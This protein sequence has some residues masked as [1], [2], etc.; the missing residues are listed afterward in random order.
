MFFAVPFVNINFKDNISQGSLS[1]Q[2]KINVHPL[3]FGNSNDFDG[4][5]F[6]GGYDG[7]S[8]GGD[9]GSGGSDY[10]GSGNEN[11][12]FLIAIMIFVVIPVCTFFIKAFCGAYKDY[13]K[14]K[15]NKVLQQSAGRNVVLLNRNEKI[16]EV[17]RQNDPTFITADFLQFSK[18]V[19][20]DIQY[21][22]SSRNLEPVRKYLHENLYN[23]TQ[24]Q[25][26]EKIAK[27]IVDV[28]KDVYVDTVCLTAYRRDREFEYVTVYL[29]AILTDYEIDER[30]RQVFRGD[31]NVKYELRYTLEFTRNLNV[32]TSSNNSVENRCPN[33]GAIIQMSNFGK[34]MFCGSI[35]TTGRYSWVLSEYSSVRDDTVDRG[36]YIEKDNNTQNNTNNN[37]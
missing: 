5:D 15:N 19:Y 32:K 1:Q 22:W 6:G 12:I 18:K 25:I 26:D 9:S 35:I 7:G 36:I 30:T 3:D 11:P 24:K 21:A 4:G 16:A 37:Q 13:T 33:C 29:K 31:P 2:A 23:Q 17:I 28:I 27:G 34:C 20:I 14:E 10:S 8:D